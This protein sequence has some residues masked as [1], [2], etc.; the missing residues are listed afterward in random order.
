MYTKA[1]VVE[2]RMTFED[3]IRYM[4]GLEKRGWRL[5]LDRMETFLAGAGLVLDETNFIHVAG[6][7]GK[8]SVTAFVQSILVEQGFRTGAFFSPYVFDVRERVQ[9]GRSLISEADFARLV[10]FLIP[11]GEALEG[12]EMGGP[13]E[14]EFKTALGFAYW[15]KKKCDWVALEVGLGGRLDATNVVTPRASVIVSIGWDH[16]A[17]LGSTL[18]E[19]AAEKAGIIKPG[20][21]VIVGKM[22]G[23]ALAVIEEIA[24]SQNSPVWR[25]G[26]EI[27]VDGD[28]V[29]LPGRTVCGLRPGLP[30]P[31]Q[32]H[33][34]AL[35]VAAV[36]ASGSGVDD[37]AI[38]RGVAGASLP[39][40]YQ[41]VEAL[42]RVWLFDGA[43]NIDAARVL[44]ESL[45]QEFGDRK[46]LLVTAML[47]GH[48]P[49]PFLGALRD[50]I[51]KVIVA[52]IDFFRA[53]NPRELAEDLRKSCSM[54]DSADTLE[55][56][57]ALALSETE[58]G[59]TIL[60]TGSFY[61]VGQLGNKLQTMRA[62]TED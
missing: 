24:A 14:F 17:I 13:T 45:S 59:E 39:G 36:V 7:N 27:L 56:T 25:F 1:Q 62:S 41:K 28:C 53:R 44:A 15:A 43:H 9:F 61:L 50:N 37:E 16:M 49:L 48:E 2:L 35:A 51:R 47:D 22:D 10:S 8:G 4:T 55:E 40:R 6:T 52:P 31:V 33:N 54:V 23:E 38:R 26:S 19:I 18:A 46:L 30:G 57:I 34:M 29:V 42:G 20:V 58:Q 21:P 12:T 60:V 11:A 3:A 5:G 32:V